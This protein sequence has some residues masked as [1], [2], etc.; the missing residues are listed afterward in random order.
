MQPVPLCGTAYTVAPGVHIDE[1]VHIYAWKKNLKVV[2]IV[3]FSSCVGVWG[4]Y[5][6]GM[7]RLIMKVI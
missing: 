4:L 3:R 1:A 7:V 6:Q 5:S 2:R